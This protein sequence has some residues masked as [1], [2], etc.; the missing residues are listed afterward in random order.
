M[1]V[2]SE[3]LTSSSFYQFIWDIFI[4]GQ[5]YSNLDKLD[6][7][8]LPKLLGLSKAPTFVFCISIDDFNSMTESERYKVKKIV[9][10][11]I[12]KMLEGKE[13]ALLFAHQ[14]CFYLSGHISEFKGK[15]EELYIL[16]ELAERIKNTAKDFGISLT[17]GID[18]CIEPS[19]EN[20]GKIAR[21]A[22]VAQRRKFF[23]GKGRIYFRYERPENSLCKSTLSATYFN[24][25]QKLLSALIGGNIKEVKEISTGLVKDIFKYNLEKLFYL[26][27]R[28]IEAGTMLVCNLIEL[29]LPE[30][31]TFQVLTD[32]IG[33]IN[34]LHDVINLAETFYCLVE[35]LLNLAIKLPCRINP[36][37]SKVK[38]IIEF[39]EDL[40]DV[41]LYKVA[42]MVNVNYTYLSRLFKK[43]LGLSFT[44]YIS[45]ERIKRAFPLLFDKQKRIGDIAI[46]AGFKNLQSFE[47]TFKHLYNISPN[48]FRKTKNKNFLDPMRP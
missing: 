33:D 34:S 43:E 19:I 39:S 1:E 31:N 35:N 44:E 12:S 11:I 2:R 37:L 28:L 20:W 46:H 41:T 4:Y 48:Q 40:S 45:R 23:E 3:D 29:G 30:S 10:E 25:Q 26:R 8:G 38:E 22:I 24:I 7:E 27:T 5:Y 18:F 17:I 21:C 42:K 15:G 16:Q 14:N 47:R 36:I 32:F 6:F 9:K 13:Y